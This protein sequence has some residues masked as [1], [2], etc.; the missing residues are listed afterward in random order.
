[1]RVGR[2]GRGEVEKEAVHGLGRDPWEDE[3]EVFA[4]RRL[5]GS[6]QVS[7]RKALVAQAWWALA[8]NPPAMTC[9]ALLANPR[10]V[11]EPEGDLLV[12]RGLAGRRDRVAKPLLAK[13]S[14]ARGSRLGWTGRAFCFDSPSRRTTRDMDC[15][16]MVLPN[17]SSMKRH[18][19]GQLDGPPR[20]GSGPRRTRFTSTACSPS[21]STSA[22]RPCGRSTKPV[23]PSTL[24]RRTAS[25]S[26]WR[27]MPAARA[28]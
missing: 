4:G 9:P 27:S 15:G 2:H 7:G 8:P 26:D 14:A 28:A 11:H 21:L 23:S 17:R 24:K 10:L 22:L 3:A 12:R 16:P 6:E 1:M 25:R 13:A 20:S 18:R 5:D 19:S